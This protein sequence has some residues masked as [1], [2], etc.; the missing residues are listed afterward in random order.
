MFGN[1]RVER[2]KLISNL[3]LR[4]QYYASLGN[5]SFEPRFQLRY[6]PWKS[7]GIKFAVG[8]YSQNFLSAMSDRDVVN[9][10][11]GFLSGPDNL[12]D[13]FNGKPVTHALQKARHA[14]AGFDY[15]ISKK[16]TI[17]I[18]SFVKLF[19]QIT[20]IN[21]DKLF[22]D[23][24]FNLDKPQRLRQNFI[25]E[26]GNIELKLET[27]NSYVD[28]IIMWLY[29]LNQYA[30]KQCANSLVIYL[31]FTSLEKKLPDSKIVIL[32]E[33]NVNTA[34]T[35]TCP[36]DSEIVIFRKEEW[37]KVLIHESFHNFALDFSDMNIY[38]STKDIL[39]I[40]PVNSEVKLYESYTE[41]W[42]EIMNALFCSFFNLKN[43]SDSEEF[44]S[45]FEFFI[46]FE[47][48]YSFF[49][50]VKTLDFMGLNYKNMY[51]QTNQSEILRNTLYKENSNVLAYYIIKTIL[52]NN[53]QGFLYW[54]K[55]NNFS[56][57]QFK[58]TS[59]NQKEFCNFI[60]R[61]Y[62]TK[63]MLDNI[64]SS[65]VCL[66]KVKKEKKY[67]YQKFLLTNMRM[68]LCELG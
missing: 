52:I 11:Y 15:R 17:N 53:Y 51:S 44:L 38:E 43:K 7:M 47:R 26:E 8:A 61:N 36:K 2:K 16:Q 41:F 29:I 4:T 22:E 60:R 24:E 45:N 34:F 20:N 32:D 25:V 57:L 49:Q 42:A 31:Y 65:E 14:V 10:F 40:F 62:K 6:M 68:S 39:A 3:G 28:A 59:S 33:I 56:L 23:D 21:R 46:N 37:F 13:S 66:Q 30:S 5:S 35:T 27:F 48:T 18:E 54:C 58:K 1:Y 63:L 12:P 9:L 67:K 64:K 19:D 55:T 50:L